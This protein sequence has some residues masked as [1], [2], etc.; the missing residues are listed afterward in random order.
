MNHLASEGASASSGHPAAE[1]AS[2]GPWDFD[3]PR[4]NIHIFQASDPN[5]RVCFM[6]SDGPTRANARLV[7][8]APDLLEA[9]QL[10]EAAE[11]AR[12]FCEECDGEG[13]PEA[14]G[15]CFP[16]FDDARVKRRLAIVKAIG[17][18]L[19]ESAPN[20]DLKIT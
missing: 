6:T 19:P 17:R 20:K 10:L 3:G 5:M 15:E 14:C 11:H 9:A 2:P 16:S 8:A 7:A 13:E 18:P 12:Q 1:I 4:S